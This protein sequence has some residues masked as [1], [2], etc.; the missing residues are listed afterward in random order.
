M[1]NVGKRWFAGTVVLPM[2]AAPVPTD[3][4]PDTN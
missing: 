3:G 2:Y 4:G 1:S